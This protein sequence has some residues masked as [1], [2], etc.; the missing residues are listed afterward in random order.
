MPKKL[1]K[2]KQKLVF[3]KFPFGK[4]SKAYSKAIRIFEEDW[5]LLPKAISSHLSTDEIDHIQ[6]VCFKARLRYII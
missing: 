5:R 1:N 6:A 3:G 4:P 2:P